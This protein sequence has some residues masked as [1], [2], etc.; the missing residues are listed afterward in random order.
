[1]KPDSEMA[2]FLEGTVGVC[3]AT[4]NEQHSLWERWHERVEWEQ[5][6]SGLME[7]VGTLVEMPVCISLRTAKI[8]GQKI[9]FW[10]A[11]SQVVDHRMIDKWLNA[12]LPKSAFR[13]HDPRQGL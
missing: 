9:I 6:C 4:D 13:D 1:M 12:A 11:T 8:N 3:E 7:T 10:R 5:N 2:K